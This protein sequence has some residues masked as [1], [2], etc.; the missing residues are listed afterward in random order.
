MSKKTSI[1]FV[2]L[3]SISLTIFAQQKPKSADDILK[4]ALSQANYYN[5]NVLVIFHAT[6]CGW[7]KR[8]IKVVNGS[9]VSNIFNN[10]FVVTYIDVRERGEMIKLVE[11]PGGQELMSRLGGGSSGVPFYVFLDSKGNVITSNAGYPSRRS[12][13]SF[14]ARIKKSAKNIDNGSLNKITEFMNKVTSD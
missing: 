2:I 14:V 9:E 13:P 1:F 3:F 4:S 12:V 5:K 6:W 10:N 7:C 8:L 11:N